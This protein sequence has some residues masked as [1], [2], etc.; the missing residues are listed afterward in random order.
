MA[1]QRMGKPVGD[2]A[3]EQVRAAAGGKADEQPQLLALIEWSLRR[4]AMRGENKNCGKCHRREP[5]DH[6]CF[7]RMPAPRALFATASLPYSQASRRG[8]RMAKLQD[9]HSGAPSSGVL[10]M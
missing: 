2:G 1:F 5:F 3:A 8:P 7:L 4:C 6:P 10:W 9:R